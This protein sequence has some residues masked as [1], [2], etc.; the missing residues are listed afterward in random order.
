M[1]PE[2]Q[3]RDAISEFIKKGVNQSSSAIGKVKAVN[4]NLCDVEMVESGVIKKAIKL[5]PIATEKGVTI[6]PAIDSF[7][8]VNSGH[9]VM[10]SEAERIRIATSEANLLETVKKLIDAIKAIR[11]MTPQGVSETPLNALEFDAVL[12]EFEKILE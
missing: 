4:G 5:N 7:V 9:I 6:R 12:Q 3:A 1:T 11:V 2:Q 10:F 8:L